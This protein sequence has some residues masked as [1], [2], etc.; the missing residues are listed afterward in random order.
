LWGIPINKDPLFLSGVKK[1]ILKNNRI[2]K[3][4]RCFKIIWFFLL[5][6]APVW[7][8]KVAQTDAQKVALQVVNSQSTLKHQVASLQLAYQSACYSGLKSGGQDDAAIYYYVYNVG[9]NEGFVI[10]AGDDIAYPVIGYSNTGAYRVEQ[11]PVNFISWMDQLQSGI[12]NAIENKLS[13][14]DRTKKAWEAYLSGESLNLYS[15]QAV[16]SLTQTKWGQDGPYNNLCPEYN[17]GVRSVTGCVATVMAQLMKYYRYPL[18]GNGRTNAYVTETHKISVPA[19]NLSSVEYNWNTMSNTYTSSSSQTAK[20]AVATIMY[21]C[22]A[23]VRMDYGKESGAYIDNAAISLIGYF[24]YDAGMQMKSRDFYTTNQWTAMLKTEMDA[25]RPV[26]Y[27]GNSNAGGHAFIC[28]GYDRNG[29]FSFNWGWEGYMNGY[30]NIDGIE[31]KNNNTI[32]IG[33]KPDEGGKPT[34][35]MKLKPGTSLTSSKSTVEQNETFTVSANFCNVGLADFTGNYGVVLLNDNGAV[36]ETIGIFNT[37]PWTLESGYYY[38]NQFDISCKVQNAPAGNYKIRAAVRPEGGSWTAIGGQ[39][40]YTDELVINVGNTDGGSFEIKLVDKTDI[41]T[42]ASAIKQGENFTVT[43][44]F[45]N[46]GAGN[47]TGY[48][49]IVL[50]DEKG[51]IKE[52]IGTYRDIPM[53]LE[54]GYR[55]TN[56]FQITCNVLNSAPGNYTIRAA[57]K[58]IEG[59]WITISGTAGYKDELPLEVIKDRTGISLVENQLIKTYILD[60][61]LHIHSPTAERIFIYST[62]GILLQTADKTEGNL[63]IPIMH[64]PKGILIIYGSSGWKSKVIKAF[65]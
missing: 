42:S 25:G 41:S 11:L 14:S 34:C 51:T 62:G 18:R 44:H 27:S 49:G 20:N 4:L 23:S 47:F 22:G 45:R 12:H 16:S 64:L 55:Y 53:T 10:I 43:A 60:Q 48:Y 46:T 31:F 35:E 36:I 37:S 3:T 52:T 6:S 40:G 29:L 17:Y 32:L 38:Q 61:Q 19:I 26:Y 30:Y 56:P 57:I 1:W 2:M 54:A 5:L 7:A 59:E 13:P 28:D 8:K 9:D 39:V 63:I 65:Y 24:N 50:L 33:I 15:S 21:H 58:P